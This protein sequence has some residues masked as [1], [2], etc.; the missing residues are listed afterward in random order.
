MAKA[1][2]V[3]F[4]RPL[5]LEFSISRRLPA[6]Q[7]SVRN[8]EKRLRRNRRSLLVLH[9]SLGRATRSCK[10][11]CHAA[12]RQVSGGFRRKKSNGAYGNK[13]KN[14]RRNGVRNNQNG[15]VLRAGEAGAGT[16]CKTSGIHTVHRC[17]HHAGLFLPLRWC[18]LTTKAYIFQEKILLFGKHCAMRQNF[19]LPGRKDCRIHKLLFVAFRLFPRISPPLA[20]RCFRSAMASLP[21]FTP[22]NRLRPCRIFYSPVLNLQTQ[23]RFS[24]TSG[25]RL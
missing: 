15:V 1:L 14:G 17:V 11:R 5:P 10:M 18:K 6:G 8:T 23:N 16:L 13:R 3:F 20:P 24:G 12:A 21:N 19:A 22:I 2:R 9:F 7:A 25:R 4:V